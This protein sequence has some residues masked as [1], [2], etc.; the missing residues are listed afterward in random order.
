ME[1]KSKSIFDELF[2]SIERVG[3]EGTIRH[4]KRTE[5]VSKDN[6]ERFILELVCSEFK[7]NKF[8]LS[9][10][11][12]QDENK[13][14]ARIVLSYLLYNN[15]SLTQKQVGEMVSRSKGTINKH[16][17]EVEGLSPKIKS[18][19]ELLVVVERLETEIKALRTK[20]Q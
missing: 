6:I 9:Q 20:I 14:Q 16:I 19:R 5:S 15:T 7:V 8:D 2:L 1:N 12:D 3:V 11:T 4:L 10:S 18:N 17:S 13:H